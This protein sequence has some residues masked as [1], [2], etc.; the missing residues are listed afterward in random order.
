MQIMY[1][2]MGDR[3]LI[4]WEASWLP[5]YEGA[6]PVRVGNAAHAQLQLDVY[7]ELMDVFYQSRVAK[8]KFGDETWA[9]ECALLEHLSEIWDEPYSGIW[10]RR[11][12]PKH[13]VSSTVLTRVAFDRGVKSS[14]QFGLKGPIDK[15]RQIR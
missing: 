10:E 2:I 3:R 4:E 7:G 14:E 11:G 15:W 6:Q 5:G 12:P 9:L 8:L 13:H 1:G